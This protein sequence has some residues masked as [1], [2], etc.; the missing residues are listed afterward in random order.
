MTLRTIL[1]CH[2]NADDI[3]SEGKFRN[4]LIVNQVTKHFLFEHEKYNICDCDMNIVYQIKGTFWMGKHHLVLYDDEKNPI[5][6]I[7]KKL[8]VLPDIISGYYKRHE[9]ILRKSGKDIGY[10]ETYVESKLRK[11]KISK[12]GWSIPYNSADDCYDIIKSKSMIA[13]FYQAVSPDPINHKYVIGYNSDADLT[14]IILISIS[15]AQI[16]NAIH[17]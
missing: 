16:D 6:E 8:I 2:R 9:C 5:G 10:V 14:E 3:I 1:K 17:D 12:R 13:K 4:Y 7:R 15:L 11:Y